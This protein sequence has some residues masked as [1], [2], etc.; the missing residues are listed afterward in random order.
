M[1]AVKPGVAIDGGGVG[2]I[3]ADKRAVRVFD[4]HNGRIALIGRNQFNDLIFDR[5]LVDFDFRA[6]MLHLFL[7]VVLGCSC[8]DRR[9]P[10]LVPSPDP[11]PA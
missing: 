9:A 6:C 1:G 4:G 5:D 11:R 3:D 7:F 2:E 8:L 10:V